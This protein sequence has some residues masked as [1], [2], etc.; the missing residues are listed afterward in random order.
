MYHFPPKKS[1]RSWY[2]IVGIPKLWKGFKVMP[3]FKDPSRNAPKQPNLP[4]KITSRFKIPLS[5]YIMQFFIQRPWSNIPPHNIPS[6]P[7]KKCWNDGLSG[8]KA[9]H[10][11]NEKECRCWKQF[12]IRGRIAPILDWGVGCRNADAGCIRVDADAQQC[13]LP[14]DK[15]MATKL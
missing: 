6:I 1:L 3:V 2:R 8:I 15:L 7:N 4:C 10:Y 5:V 14:W 11:R 13:L 12:G 9:V